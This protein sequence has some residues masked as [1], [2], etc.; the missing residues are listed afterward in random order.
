[1]LVLSRS[2]RSRASISEVGYAVGRTV[3]KIDSFA[4]QLEFGVVR[5]T[6]LE[7]QWQVTYTNG[8]TELLTQEQMTDALALAAQNEPSKNDNR[9][10]VLVQQEPE[11]SP[12]SL[13][14]PGKRKRTPVDY[15]KLNDMLYAGEQDSD[16]DETYEEGADGHADQDSDDYKEGDDSPLPPA[17]TTKAPKR[18]GRRVQNKEL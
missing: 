14:L 11:E 10:Q 17:S 5:K 6:V 13:I 2:V 9:P 3:A 12:Q 15:R 18:K 4:Q 8:T 7:P 16:L 1:M